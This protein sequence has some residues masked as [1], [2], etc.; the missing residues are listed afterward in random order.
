MDLNFREIYPLTH[1]IRE[2]LKLARS[3]NAVLTGVSPVMGAVAMQEYDLFTVFDG[4]QVYV[5][6]RRNLFG[7]TCQFEVVRGEQRVG[8]EL[9]EFAGDCPGQRKT[10]VCTGTATN[11]INQYQAV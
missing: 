2:Y 5:G 1:M 8:P 10:V 3:F 11:F 6:C 7:K 9:A 4:I